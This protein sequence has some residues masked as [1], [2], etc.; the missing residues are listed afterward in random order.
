MKA[1]CRALAAS[2]LLWTA[3]SAAAANLM[4]PGVALE[5]STAFLRRLNFPAIFKREIPVVNPKIKTSVHFEGA[6]SSPMKQ[7]TP[8]FS[9]TFTINLQDGVATNNGGNN[10]NNGGGNTFSTINSGSSN[11][12][13]NNGNPNSSPGNSNN[14]GSPGGNSNGNSNSQM[15]VSGM[16]NAVIQNSP[17]ANQPPSQSSSIVTVTS[18]SSAFTPTITAASSIRDPIQQPSSARTNN[19]SDKSRTA[20]LIA[21]PTFAFVNPIQPEG[22]EL[23]SNTTTLTEIIDDPSLSSNFYDSSWLAKNGKQLTWQVTPS[24]DREIEGIFV[25]FG[26]GCVNLNNTGSKIEKSLDR[27]ALFSVQDILNSSSVNCNLNL[28][29]RLM[30]I[31]STSIHNSSLVA[32]LIYVPSE[33]FERNS[34]F[35]GELTN[36]FWFGS[37][38]FSFPFAVVFSLTD[39]SEIRG[40]ITMGIGA[41]DP[42]DIVASPWSSIAKIK[43]HPSMTLSDSQLSEIRGGTTGLGLR[44]FRTIWNI[45]IY[46]SSDD[47]NN[48]WSIVL[49]FFISMFAVLLV[50][51]IPTYI[52]LQ[53]RRRRLLEMQANTIQEPIPE[54][55]EASLLNNIP[56]VTFSP[57]LAAALLRSPV[58]PTDATDASLTQNPQLLRNLHQKHTSKQI[59]PPP[60]AFD[61]NGSRHT[62]VSNSI[63]SEE[64]RLSL[65]SIQSM[66]SLVVTRNTGAEKDDAVRD[67]EV[68]ACAVCI[69]DFVNGDVL[70][71]LACSHVFHRECIDN[72]L[73]TRSVLCPLCRLD[74][75]PGLIES[76]NKAVKL[77]VVEENPF[78]VMDDP[79]ADEK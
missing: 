43:T 38:K 66:Q 6:T 22:V 46:T 51:W 76:Q 11:G 45:T 1:L 41:L 7:T 12:N 65:N 77:D 63:T 3:V 26:D 58:T 50:I 27:I 39:F 13:S 69:E 71:V 18:S 75:R 52:F 10:G 67:E 33:L 4:A 25:D 70:R 29:T 61:P 73:T 23:K 48:S 34:T 78:E 36:M 24:A 30:R 8:S 35:S 55:V 2:L 68:P 21:S 5:L 56:L 14:N 62:S 42:L 31:Q 17:Q 19:S 28:E 64:S 59:R 44:A 40:R 47:D 9:R 60:A 15:S 74:V 72:W 20:S 37:E 57:A 54:T 79:F 16:K 32:A 49:Q 53:R